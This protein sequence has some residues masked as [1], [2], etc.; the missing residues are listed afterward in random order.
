MKKQ[1]FTLAEAL[2]TMGIIGIVAALT[3]PPLITSN[4]NQAYASKLT[5]LASN[6]ENAF[7]TTIV[8]ENVGSLYETTL[9]QDGAINSNTDDDKI[10][11]FAGNLGK[12]LI[13]SGYEKSESDFYNK[14]G[15][16]YPMNNNGSKNTG[17]LLTTFDSTNGYITILTKNGGAIFIKT[18]TEPSDFDTLKS[19]AIK[20]GSSYYTHAGDVIIDV[21][22]IG[23]PNTLGRDIFWFQVSENGILYPAG[24]KDVARMEKAGTWDSETSNKFSCT[25]SDKGTSEDVRGAGCTARVIQEGYKISY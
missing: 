12:N 3:A 6:I 19:D 8:Q 2:I 13:I 9:W 23:S 5:V 7:T 24:G 22:G 15:G 10:A 11:A 21:N 25:N 1:G 16:F 14:V 4:K 20:N 17:K 18:N